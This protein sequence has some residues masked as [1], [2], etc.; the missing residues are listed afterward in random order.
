MRCV[1][2]RILYEHLRWALLQGLLPVQRRLLFIQEGN[3]CMHAFTAWDI[4]VRSECDKLHRI[5]HPRYA[6]THNL[7]V[8][9]CPKLNL[10][11]ST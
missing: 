4:H 5:L 10:P 7:L 8:I 3:I 9:L 6:E 1:S 2:P 11:L